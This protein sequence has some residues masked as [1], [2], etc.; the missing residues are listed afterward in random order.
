MD[1]A[2]LHRRIRRL[3]ILLCLSLAALLTAAFRSQSETVTTR[4]L[5]VVDGQ[6]RPRFLIGAPLPDPQVQGKVYPRSR[7]VPGIM[8]L[9]TLGN[10]TGGMGLFDDIEGGGLCFD[11]ATAEAV[12][13]T[14]IS[15]LNR[16]GLTILDPPPAG[17]AVGRSGAS[18]LELGLQR[19]NAGLI[20]HD[21]EGK[22]RLRLGV[23]SAGIPSLELLDGRGAVVRS[24]RP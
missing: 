3:E 1:S 16:V 13:L 24:L 11:Y 4:Q 7:P 22:P 20:L 10:E 15:K 17:A 21:A 18:R 2:P 19:R 12:C 5:R 9:D 23:D 14:K 6:G 8:F